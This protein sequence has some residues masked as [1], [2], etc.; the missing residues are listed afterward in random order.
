MLVVRGYRYWRSRISSGTGH[1][2]RRSM[3]HDLLRL[4]N[5]LSKDGRGKTELTST[6]I[7]CVVLT[8]RSYVSLNVF[9]MSFPLFTCESS[10]TANIVEVAPQVYRIQEVSFGV[11][12]GCFPSYHQAAVFA[13]L[14]FGWMELAENLSE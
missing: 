3:T 11:I 12:Y 6:Y 13:V 10:V 1:G 14:C 2:C 7:Y 8:A 9:Q 4:R 5:R